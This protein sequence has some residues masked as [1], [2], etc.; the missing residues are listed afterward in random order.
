PGD[1]VTL[2]AGQGF[3]S[4]NWLPGNSTSQS[5]QVTTPGTYIVNVVVNNGQCNSTGADTVEVVAAQDVAVPVLS[6]NTSVCAG[7]TVT[8]SLN[9][10]YN[11]YLWSDGS[12]GATV[13][14]E[15]GQYSVTVSQN[16]S[17]GTASSSIN[18]TGTPLPDA[19]FT[20]NAALLTAVTTGV[21]YQWYQ[22]GS[23]I[24]GA[25]QGTF[26]VSQTGNYSL[27][28]TKDGCSSVSEPV[29]VVISGLTSE[30]EVVFTVYP[31]PADNL[32][33]VKADGLNTDGCTA[34][35]YSTNGNITRQLEL[36][37]NNGQLNTTI[38]VVDIPA[39]VYVLRIVTAAATKTIRFIK[40]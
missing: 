7:D 21:T 2:D 26:L 15:T 1:V 23:P 9:Q 10:V 31:N 32:L 25:T 30:D 11:T 6:Y 13:S 22:D 14:G 16:G 19:S 18:A 38:D 40:Q 27:Q 35:I 24:N 28:V 3:T 36:T 39:G 5:V 8:I 4:Y 29:Q 20:V 33:M 12:T 37:T 17:C 34:V